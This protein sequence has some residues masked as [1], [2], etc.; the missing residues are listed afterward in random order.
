[1]RRNDGRWSK[2]VIEWY[3][4][5]K[6]RPLGRLPTRWSDSLSIR[7]NIVHDRMRCLVHWSTRAQTRNDW[8]GCYDPQQ[9]NR[10]V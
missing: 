10:R 7:Y 3:P 1:M 4:R 9:G 5:E 8:K 2:A 6:K